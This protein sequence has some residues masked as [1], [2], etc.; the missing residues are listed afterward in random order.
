M[1]DCRGQGCRI[2][3][4]DM[5]KALSDIAFSVAQPI[6][7]LSG[8]TWRWL[9]IVAVVM[10]DLAWA[11]WLGVSGDLSLKRP[12]IILVIALAVIS[13]IFR[14][15]NFHILG[16]VF[17]SVAQVFIFLMAANTLCCLAMAASGNAP[18]ADGLLAR[19]DSAMGL[20]WVAWW[21]FLQGFKTV[22][23]LITWIYNQGK[24][25]Y[26]LVLFYLCI[27]Q[28]RQERERLLWAAMLSQY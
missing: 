26:G 14:R 5:E 19:I 17:E 7:T 20:N 1:L 27:V 24:N 3:Q 21:N 13:F 4:V 15:Y 11:A 9:L 2:I 18:L 8:G 25:E 6:V 16:D 22:N 28:R 10:V 12:V 23:S